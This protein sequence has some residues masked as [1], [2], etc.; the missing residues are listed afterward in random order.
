MARLTTEGIQ[1]QVTDEKLQVHKASENE[2]AA[3][4]RT[5]LILHI[6]HCLREGILPISFC[7]LTLINV[8]ELQ[9]VSRSMVLMVEVPRHAKLHCVLHQWVVLYSH[10]V[11]VPWSVVRNLE[12]ERIKLSLY[13]ISLMTR[14]KLSPYA[15][16]LMT[17][18]RSG[19]CWNSIL[20]I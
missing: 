13:A 19:K 20:T 9:E 18:G 11:V 16:S 6:W 12:G 17:R 7:N 15:I 1:L 2:W 10:E 4:L 5:I 14:I 8:A 3:S